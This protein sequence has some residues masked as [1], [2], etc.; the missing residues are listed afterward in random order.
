MCN[1]GKNSLNAS[2]LDVC[3]ETIVTV[4]NLQY[5]DTISAK[6][7][8]YKFSEGFMCRK[9]AVYGIEYCLKDFVTVGLELDCKETFEYEPACC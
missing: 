8:L 2:E 6:L 7:V 3:S 9:V 4:N 5:A 1:T